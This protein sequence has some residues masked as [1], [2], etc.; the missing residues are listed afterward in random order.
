MRDG[1]RSRRERASLQGRVCIISQLTHKYILS[2]FQNSGRDWIPE[3]GIAEQLWDWG[4]GTIGDRVR[5]IVSEFR[6]FGCKVVIEAVGKTRISNKE[7]KTR[8]QRR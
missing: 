3:T 6:N 2:P 8:P 7:S 1:Q 4:E 5:K